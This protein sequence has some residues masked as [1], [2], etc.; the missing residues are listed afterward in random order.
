MLGLVGAAI[1]IA[2]PRS[3]AVIMLVGAVGGLIVNGAFFVPGA[4]LLGIGALLAFLGR[5]EKKAAA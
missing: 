1:A 5:N 3:A 2:K 4:I